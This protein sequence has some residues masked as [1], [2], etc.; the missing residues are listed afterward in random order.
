MKPA[1][2]ALASL[3]VVHSATP[4]SRARHR[5]SEWIHLDADHVIENAAGI[6]VQHADS[7]KLTARLIGRD[8][9]LV[10]GRRHAFVPARVTS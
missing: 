8:P 7:G 1:F 4:E 6:A 10:R 3:V 2:R 5:E 9:T